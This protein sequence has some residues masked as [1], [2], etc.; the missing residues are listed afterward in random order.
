[1]LNDQFRKLLVGA[2]ALLF[3]A[4]CSDGGGSNP[5]PSSPAPTNAPATVVISGAITYDRVP[6]TIA[7]GLNFSA[8]QQRAARGVVVEALDS[9]GAVIDSTVTNA[10][11]QYSLSTPSQ[12]QVRIQARAQLLQSGSSSWN[13]TV[14]D[15]TN[16]NAVYVLRG[17]LESSGAAN[18][19]RNLNAGLGWTG[20]S[21][22][23]T[24]AAAPFAALDSIYTAMTNL[25]ALS[26]VSGLTYPTL[27]VFWSPQN[28]AVQ[29]NIS[30]GEIS[31][32]SYTRI[33]GV[34][35]ILIQGSENND[36]DEFDQH[37][38]VHEFGH[39]LEDQLSRLDSIG[40]PH[41]LSDR[42]DARLAFSEGFATAFAVLILSDQIYIDTF[43]P[44]QGQSFSFNVETVNTANRGWF[45]ESSVFRLMYDIFDSSNEGADTVTFGAGPILDTMLSP[46]FT[47]DVAPGTIFLYLSELLSQPGA[48][49]AGINAI[50][51]NELINGSNSY[52]DGET[53]DG[54]LAIS[55]PPVKTVTVGGGSTVVCSF[56]DLG[57]FNKL[58][59]RQLIRLTVPASA[60]YTLTMTRAS[61]PASRDPDFLIFQAS[62]LVAIAGSASVDIEQLTTFLAAGVYWIDAYDFG[63]I[64]DSTPSGDVCYD[65]SVN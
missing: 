13:V 61:G 1:M 4:A 47:G 35:T 43:G 36:T 2:A 26:S 41:S 50:A 28:I 51:A 22:G 49:V 64:D 54:G 27:Q 53:N 58:G 12:T 52:G 38:I 21:Y 57:D 56:D 55:L 24:R 5:S 62:Q 16:N 37:V 63:N 19:T 20:A 23:A 46:S 8:V 3:S 14:R 17:T 32:T 65:F 9:S 7:S 11:G 60:N 25:V 10:S 33:S 15:N 39:Y 59:N 48:N 44:L 30:D 40:G 45:N 6:P 31:S 42:L 18:S 29:G 34:P